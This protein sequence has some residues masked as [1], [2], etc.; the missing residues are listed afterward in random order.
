MSGG[1]FLDL[2]HKLLKPGGIFHFKT[3]N[4]E[5]FDWSK[6]EI[7]NGGKLFNIEFSTEDL[8]AGR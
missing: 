5:L 3:D 1:K 7:A 2:Y 6:Q 4:Q 8:H